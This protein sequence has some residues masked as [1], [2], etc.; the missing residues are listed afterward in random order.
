MSELTVVHVHR[1]LPGN[2]LHINAQ[3]ISLL[4]VIVQHG[5]QEVVCRADGVEIPGEMEV[6][7]LH[8][9]HLSITAA[10]R[11][12]LYAEHRSQGGFPQSNNGILADPPQTVRQPDR[13]G[14][15]TLTSGSGRNGSD[16]D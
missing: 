5:R 14:G 12:T 13:G 11:T 15:F 7:I 6:D 4:N 9:Y 2:L 3:G 16:Q 8:G 10:G 1:T